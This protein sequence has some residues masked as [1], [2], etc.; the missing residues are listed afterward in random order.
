[1]NKLSIVALLLSITHGV[2]AQNIDNPVLP[3]VADAGVLKYNGKYYIGG[4]YTDGSFYVS[5]DLVK[6]EGP[7]HVIDMDNEWTKGTGAGNDQI[8]A[9]DL[10]YINGK[11]HLYWSVNYWGKDK[12]IVHAAHAES[13]N[14][15]GP[16]TEP[17]KDTWLD[18]RIDP[19]VFV[20]DDGELYMYLVRFTDGNTI[21]ARPMS[22]PSTFS[23]HP[24]YQFASLPGTWE[25][26]D[27]RVAEGPWVI[28]YR[29]R[30]Y[31]MY[32]ANHTSTEWGNYQLGVAEADHPL[33]FSHGTKYPYP[34]LKSNQV[35]LEEQYADLLL[36]SDTYDSAFSYTLEQPSGKWNSLNFDDSSWKK[37]K[38]GFASEM[39]EGATVKKQGTKWDTQKIYLRKTF[40]PDNSSVGNIALRMTHDGDTK[41]YLNNTLIY[42]KKGMG[43]CIVNLSPEQ[44]NLLKDGYNVLAIESNKG[45]R[46]YINASLFDMKADK[47]DDILFTPGQPNI[48]KGPNGFEWWLI[49]MANKNNDR[50]GQYI[51][52]IHFF[53]KTMYAE[54]LTA[55]NTQGYHPAPAKPTFG[56]LFDTNESI[57]NWTYSNKTWSV[58]DGKFIAPDLQEYVLLKDA[59]AAVSY[60]FEAGVNTTSK[61][62]IIAWRKDENN[63]MEVGLDSKNN[64]WYYTIYKDGKIVQQEMYSLANDFKHGV[65]HTLSVERDGQTFRLKIDGIPAPQQPLITTSI[66]EAGLPGLFSEGAGSVFDGI[67]YTV[68]WDEC[69]TAITGWDDLK[70]G[71][72]YS[73]TTDGLMPYQ[74]RFEAFKG[75]LLSQYEFSTQIKNNAGAGMAGVYS[76]YVD[77]KNYVKTVIDYDK[78]TLEITIREKGKETGKQSF[79][80]KTIQPHYADMRYT[81]FIEKK[82]T[83]SYPV[84]IDEILL[85]R[86]PV[87]DEDAFIENMF[88]KLYVEYLHKEKWLPLNGK[89]AVA[90]NP[91]YNSMTFAPVKTEGLR[92]TNRGAEDLNPYIYKIQVGEQLKD[93]Y[94]VRTVKLKDAILIFVDGRQ[95]CRL[96]VS[97][98]SSRVGLYSESCKPVYNGIMRYHLPE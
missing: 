55:S 7:I 17:E 24:V 54:G 39:V 22:S 50:R 88:D 48:L 75:D 69:D 72:G 68:G 63:R 5:S 45:R 32:N 40:K 31:M 46:N 76:A 83:F 85:N 70:N 21:W 90:G 41:V 81:D 37:G 44:R 93:S 12:H 82:Y 89:I 86:I 30:Y 8:H 36:F 27:N 14:V 61:A 1:M 2:W 94:N 33:R 59:Q 66:K 51:N 52:R 10:V 15:L 65:F 34:L 80:L 13:E 43:Y 71:A 47:A 29:N 57:K 79:S 60:L 42:D 49:Y 87:H 77:D 4:V 91:L 56:D 67:T 58:S 25:T 26:E 78:K 92:F 98:P 38:P 6:W 16:Y 95:V 62:G 28:K 53:D 23:D 96:D 11:F 20:D 19:Q 35:D 18:S 84:L 74:D 64:S 9:N 3:G 97:L 73:V